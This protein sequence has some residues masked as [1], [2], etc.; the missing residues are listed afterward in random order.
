MKK[1]LSQLLQRLES[2]A[3]ENN[4]AIQQGDSEK[5]NQTVD[6]IFK[7]FDEIKNFGDVGLEKMKILMNAQDLAVRATVAGL[8]LHYFTKDALQTLQEVASA[9]SGILGFRAEQ[10]IARWEEGTWDIR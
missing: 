7:Y 10:A 2:A 6:I 8:L 9:D 4:I 3:V 5:A 1:D